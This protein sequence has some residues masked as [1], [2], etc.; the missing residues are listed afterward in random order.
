MLFSSQSSFW[1]QN[2]SF[3]WDNRFSRLEHPDR[4]HC[5]LHQAQLMQIGLES[6][7]TLV[8]FSQPVTHGDT[9]EGLQQKEAR[10]W[11][12]D[13]RCEMGMIVSVSLMPT[14]TSANKYHNSTALKQNQQ[15]E[16]ELQNRILMQPLQKPHS[17]PKAG[18]SLFSRVPIRPSITKD[19]LLMEENFVLEIYRFHTNFSHQIS[20]M[21]K[22]VMN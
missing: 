11:T 12:K 5:K 6:I 16:G 4:V 18:E 21:K 1:R 14:P 17:L 19:C 7:L 22:K 3:L 15:T 10:K 20:S 13:I 2:Y 9:G 8:P